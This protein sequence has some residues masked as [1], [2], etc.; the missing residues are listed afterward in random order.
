MLEAVR[1]M[2]RRSAE[3]FFATA[4]PVE[5]VTAVA[6]TDDEDLLGHVRRPEIRAAA[7]RGILARLDEF[8]V[9]EQLAK[10]HGVARFD[11]TDGGE[12]RERHALRFGQEG[13][14]LLED[15]PEDA[16][17]D[18]AVRT[19]VL[20]FVRLVSGERNAALEFLG[21]T[22]D[23][24]GDEL[25]ALDV[26]SLFRVPGHDEVALDPRTLNPVDVATVLEGVPTRHLRKVMGGDIR[27]IV[28]GEIFRRLPEFVDPGRAAKVR[29]QVGFRLTGGPGQEPDRYL[30]SVDRGAATVTSGEAGVRRDATVTCEGHDFLRLATGHL[31]PVSGV[32]RGHLKVKGDRSKALLLSSLI[33]IPS[34]RGVASR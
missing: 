12:V 19:S 27:G 6:A 26:G 1:A 10:L 7:V 29:L 31:N 23:I 25:M 24:E 34:A 33:D 9:P 21:G 2:D 18:V 5:L 8:A 14:A 15:H 22:L 11:L 16:P 17:R 32:L 13:I 4:D 20:R 30:V 28:L 3:D